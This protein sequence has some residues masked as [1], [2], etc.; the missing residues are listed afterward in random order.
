MGCFHDFTAPLWELF[1][2]NALLLIC[3]LFYLAWWAVAFRPGS[4]GK[5]AGA[6]FIA[7]AFFTGLGAVALICLAVGAL[8]QH[9]H[10]VSVWY[11]LIGTAALYLILLLVTAAVFHRTVTS[12]L[13]IIHVWAALELSSVAVLYGTGRFCIALASVQAVLIG[14][15]VV[16]GVICYVLFYRLSGT[17]GYWDGMVPLAADAF[18]MAVFLGMMAFA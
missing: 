5:M 17:A 3:S 4:T 7:L 14:M 1:A 18:V 2:G 10:A 6:G 9:S 15:A 16:A 12:E 11:I 13:L 8:S